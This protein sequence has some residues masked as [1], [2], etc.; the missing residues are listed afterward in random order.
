MSAPKATASTGTL[1]LH[2]HH[3]QEAEL[4]DAATRPTAVCSSAGCGRPVYAAG[5]CKLHQDWAW[6]AAGCPALPAEH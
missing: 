4:L 5:V 3:R 2:E 1:T 6:Y